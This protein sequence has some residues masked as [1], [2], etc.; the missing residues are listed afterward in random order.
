ME[1]RNTPSPAVVL[2]LLAAA[3]ALAGCGPVL[4][5]SITDYIVNT[6][7]DTNDGVC[8]VADCSLREAVRNANA[9]PGW[10]TIT[11]PAGAYT[12]SIAGAEEDAAAT[13]DL[14]I[15]DD[16]TIVGEGVP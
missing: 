12:L 6:T 4:D 11:L 9:C 5:C 13:G 10:Q 16:V 8:N 3:I 14:D 1:H 2:L 7:A 15:T